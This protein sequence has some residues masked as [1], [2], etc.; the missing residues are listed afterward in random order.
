MC[1]SFVPD[2]SRNLGDSFLFPLPAFLV[3][4]LRALFC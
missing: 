1:P 3:A 4:L 2:L